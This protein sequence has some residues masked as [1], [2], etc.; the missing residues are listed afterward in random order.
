MPVVPSRSAT[1][2][3]FGLHPSSVTRLCQHYTGTSFKAWCQSLRCAHAR[4][5]LRRYPDLTI[6]ECAREWGFADPRH[7]RRV[8]RKEFGLT[9]ARDRIT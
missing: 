2:A 6:A 1:A 9:P 7:F 3:E 5:L 8:Y 4:R